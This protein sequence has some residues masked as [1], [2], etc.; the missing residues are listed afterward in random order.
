MVLC[1]SYLIFAKLRNSIIHPTY[2]FV[3]SLRNN[4]HYTMDIMHCSNQLRY[5][6]TQA[7]HVNMCLSKM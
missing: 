6:V 2:L 4:I 3:L 7:Q 5:S 1:I